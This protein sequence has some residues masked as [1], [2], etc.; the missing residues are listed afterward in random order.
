MIFLEFWE[1]DGEIRSRGRAGMV[2][3]HRFR[4]KE[5]KGGRSG[6]SLRAA[7]WSEDGG[8]PRR[9][10]AF[11]SRRRKRSVISSHFF[12]LVFKIMEMGLLS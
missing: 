2:P 6:V 5:M 11:I 1:D 4:L 7:I 10:P 8:A 12:E 3:P 9:G